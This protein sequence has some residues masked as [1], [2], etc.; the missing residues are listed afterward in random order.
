MLKTN[1]FL[2]VFER[3]LDALLLVFIFDF[4]LVAGQHAEIYL[5]RHF[6]QSCVLGSL[7]VVRTRRFIVS[8]GWRTRLHF[9]VNF[10]FAEFNETLFAR[11][12]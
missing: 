7:V 9:K 8:F 6:K 11:F 12:E 4:G 5:R 10:S 2:E 3:D 1:E